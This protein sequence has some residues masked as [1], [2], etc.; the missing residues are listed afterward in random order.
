MAYLV[1]TG[2]RKEYKLRNRIIMAK[3]TIL[4]ERG[5]GEALYPHTLAQLVT[6]SDGGNVDE[7]LEKAKFK[8][9]VDMWNA[10]CVASSN[11]SVNII[12]RNT[13]GKYDPEN[14]P[15]PQHP[16]Y[17]NKLWLTYE[18]AIEVMRIPDVKTGPENNHTLGNSRARTLFPIYISLVQNL[19]TVC[20]QMPNLEV[21]R[22]VNYYIVNNGNNPDTYTMNVDNTRDIF[23]GCPKLREI[24][25]VL[26][27]NNNDVQGRHFYNAFIG[28]HKL[29]T[30]WIQGIC[31]DLAL[32]HCE[33]IKR[34][35]WAYMIE[36]AAN[37]SAI[38]VTVHPDVYAKLTGDTT[39]AAAA[40]LTAGEEAAWRQVLADAA[41]KNI[42]FT[43]T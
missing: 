22:F 2:R 18:E 30:L 28:A 36:H 8:V 10:R 39:N 40:T 14:A 25:G 15:D 1:G 34:E 3:Q 19:Q 33:S 5:T 6:T 41:E 26:R 35:C 23:C 20:S 11:N 24:Q 37:T 29:E 31:K 43:T 27:L 12:Q 4:K 9:F 38:T 42:T 21:V 13:F 7:G 32:K 16:F 17:L